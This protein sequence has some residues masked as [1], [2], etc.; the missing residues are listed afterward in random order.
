MTECARQAL[1]P[2][3]YGEKRVSER[4]CDSSARSLGIGGTWSSVRH[5]RTGSLRRE[6]R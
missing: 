4:L 2:M 5:G 3:R 6:S 1:P